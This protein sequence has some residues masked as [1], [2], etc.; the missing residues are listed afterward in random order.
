MFF[1]GSVFGVQSVADGSSNGGSS[2]APLLASLLGF[3]KILPKN[4][5][6]FNLDE[7]IARASVAPQPS[8]KTLQIAQS[9]LFFNKT[10]FTNKAVQKFNR[11]NILNMAFNQLNVFH[12]NGS[13]TVNL[14][15]G[16]AGNGSVSSEKKS[17]KL[18]R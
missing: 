9:S 12:I 10:R 15:L 17:D 18:L 4:P 8:P 7:N 3:G 5:H 16:D 13:S 14:S 2:S 1:L 11:S 6:V